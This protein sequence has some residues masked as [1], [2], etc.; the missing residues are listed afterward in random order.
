MTGLNMSRPTQ[1][2]IDTTA[3]QHN[4]KRVK[5]DAP[6]SQMVAMLKANAYGHGLLRVAACVPDDA[7]IGVASQEE[8]NVLRTAGYQQRIL[9]MSGF[10]NKQAL[11]QISEQGYDIVI[12]SE[13]QLQYLCDTTLPKP[14]QVWLKLNTGMN[15]LGIDIK[16]CETCLTRLNRCSWVASDIILMSHFAS[17]DNL[18][19]GSAYQQLSLFREATDHLSLPRSMANSA[20]IMALPDAHFDWVRPGIMLYGISPFAKRD[21]K[22]NL[23]PAMHFTS[24]IISKRHCQMGERIGY[25]GIYTCEQSLT[26]A[27]VPVGY[28]DGY[29][30][31]V[32]KTACVSVDGTLCPIIGRVSMDML[33]IDISSC[34]EVPL[35]TPVELWGASLAIEQV[36][37]AANT[38]AYELVCKIQYRGA[39]RGGDLES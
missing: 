36:A 27:I 7:I 28:G 11:L 24:K 34:A 19:E 3:I 31:V 2:Y 9:L 17:A 12:H 25:G 4:I 37:L 26:M 38:I 5:Q 30:R 8:A 33:S 23:Q 22:Y 1:I 10:F 15:R 13:E 18:A 20:A 21:A 16:N 32:D 39:P 14:V 29:P 6:N 35:G